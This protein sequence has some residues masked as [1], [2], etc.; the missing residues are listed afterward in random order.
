M[1]RR[2]FLL[3]CPKTLETRQSKPQTKGDPPKHRDVTLGDETA[4][5]ARALK[6]RLKSV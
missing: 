2:C 1:T 4:L 5:S 3:W 6:L